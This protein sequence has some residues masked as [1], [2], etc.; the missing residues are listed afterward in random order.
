MTDDSPLVNPIGFDHI[1]LKTRDI[2]RAI[3]F[4]T[5]ILGLRL[6]RA[7]RD[8]QGKIRFASL[9]AGDKLI[10]LQPSD[11]DW[12]NVVTGFNHVAILVEPVDLEELAVAFREQGI[13]ITQ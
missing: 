3:N 10:D 6:V 9:R 5:G 1:N 4:Y 13:E 2:D 12:S 7:E 11:D 8:A